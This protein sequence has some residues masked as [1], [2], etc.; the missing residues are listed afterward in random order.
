[1]E[2]GEAAAAVPGHVAGEHEQQGAGEVRGAAHHVAKAAELLLRV[3]HAPGG[4]GADSDHGERQPEAEGGHESEA[5]SELLHLHADDQ[6]GE[7]GR[8]RQEAAREAEEDDL[9]GGDGAVQEAL[10][11]VQSV[12]G[13]VCILKI[14]A[15]RE[16]AV[17]VRVTVVVL[18]KAEGISVRMAVVGDGQR[19]IEFVRFR[20]VGGGFEIAVSGGKGEGLA[21]A[22]GADR[23][24]G[25]GGRLK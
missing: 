14:F 2:R 17:M 7:G 21:R 13:L 24:D 12:R 10:L 18:F 23:F 1:M 20:D 4:G 19:E 5:E 6:H 9:R 16:V 11:N 25:N 15:G 3:L 22:I 8:A